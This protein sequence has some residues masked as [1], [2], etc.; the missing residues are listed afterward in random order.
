MVTRT[1]ENPKTGLHV[2]TELTRF[3]VQQKHCK[4]TMLQRKLK[5]KQH[6]SGTKT[7]AYRSLKRSME[8]GS[9]P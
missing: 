1:G 9:K 3:A 6:G 7:D 4:A 5:Q 2:C 8:A